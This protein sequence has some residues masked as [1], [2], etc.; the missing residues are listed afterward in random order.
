MP[1]LGTRAGASARGYGIFGGKNTAPS[2]EY[3]IVAGGGGGGDNIISG[4]GGHRPRRQPPP[5]EVVVKLL[6]EDPS[7]YPDA[8]REGIRR[9]LEGARCWR[10][11]GPGQACP[12]SCR[13][14]LNNPA[15]ATRSRLP[16][17]HDEAPRAPPAA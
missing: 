17:G 5:R 3:L 15:H 13:G 16:G 9:V 7:N 14:T 6:S 2:V 10:N 1:L 12:D 4:G 11:A 8:P